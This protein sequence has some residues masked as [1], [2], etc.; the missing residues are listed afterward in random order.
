M[1]RLFISF[2]NAPN[3]EVNFID[4]FVTDESL[5]LNFY[6]IKDFYKD[7]IQKMEK[8]LCLILGYLELHPFNH[9]KIKSL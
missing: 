7:V 9:L 8:C 5:D 1:K 6:T 4:C 3:K 2:S